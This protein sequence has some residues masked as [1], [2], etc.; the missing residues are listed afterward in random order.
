MSNFKLRKI[1][2]SSIRDLMSA[3][4][5]LQTQVALAE[6]SGLEQPTIGRILKATTALTVD[7]IE[8]I[9]HAFNVEPYVLF[10]YKKTDANA[11]GLL[12]DVEKLPLAEQDQ[13]Y[14]FI[15]FT[16]E[17]SKPA[18][19]SRVLNSSQTTE[20]LPKELERRATI[21]A[22]RSLS[23]EKKQLNHDTTKPTKI[24]TKLQN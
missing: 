8:R 11:S 12:A 15:R 13:I 5:L 20:P 19:Q 23:N 10:G 9:A 22:G 17:Q 7:S 18:S 14:K 24:N 16:I 3:S 6:A 1:V 2:A 4:E 21:A